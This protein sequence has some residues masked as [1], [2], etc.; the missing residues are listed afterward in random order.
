MMKNLHTPC[1]VMCTKPLSSESRRWVGSNS[2]N[3]MKYWLGFQRNGIDLSAQKKVQ[4]LPPS[5]VMGG[6]GG[7]GK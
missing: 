2:R 7:T 3:H 4:I 1:R 6:G 5:L